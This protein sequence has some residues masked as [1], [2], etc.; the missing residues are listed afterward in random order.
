MYLDWALLTDTSLHTIIHHNHQQTS[1]IISLCD[2]DV[3]IISPQTRMK[4][5]SDDAAIKYPLGLAVRKLRN[6]DRS[7]QTWVLAPESTP[8]S[9]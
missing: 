2:R 3:I 9:R 1:S 7:L 4:R 5:L 8:E 6:R